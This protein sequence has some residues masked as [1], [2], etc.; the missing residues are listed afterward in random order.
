MDPGRD[1]PRV[2]R[3]AAGRVP[4]SHL[5]AGRSDHRA[6]WSDVRDLGF[7]NQLSDRPAPRLRVGW[8]TIERPAMSHFEM[9]GL[10]IPYLNRNIPKLPIGIGDTLR[11]HCYTR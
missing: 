7:L 10:F 11:G 2:P 1:R 3:T 5:R 9:A 6:S 8:L 4:D